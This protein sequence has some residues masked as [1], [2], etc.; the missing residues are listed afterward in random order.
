MTLLGYTIIKGF[1]INI[2]ERQFA[3]ALHTRDDGCVGFSFDHIKGLYII[4]K[5]LRM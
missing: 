4:P 3:I 1:K 2:K 5:R